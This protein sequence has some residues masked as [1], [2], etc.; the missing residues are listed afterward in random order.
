[1]GGERGGEKVGESKGSAEGRAGDWT[2]GDERGGLMRVRGREGGGEEAGVGFGEGGETV[3]GA[4]RGLLRGRVTGMSSSVLSD[5]G[6]GLLERLRGGGIGG[7]RFSVW[8]G[9]R[10]RF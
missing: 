5:C 4:T 6:S 3:D 9:L 2:E 10:G 8:I 1:V 7:W